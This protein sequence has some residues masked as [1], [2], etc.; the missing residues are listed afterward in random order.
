MEQAK[1]DCILA[2]ASANVGIEF[3]SAS[4]FHTDQST[5]CKYPDPFPNPPLM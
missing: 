3:T 5:D 4:L 1:L 2:R